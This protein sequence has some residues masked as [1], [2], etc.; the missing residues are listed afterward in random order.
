MANYY[1][2]EELRAKALN[3]NQEDVNALGEWF[4]Q[5]GDCYWNGEYYNADD[6]MRLFPV[7]EEM[8]EDEW[9]LKRYEFR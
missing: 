8:A 2:Y 1:E 5:Y 3:G 9:E 7:Y 4:E 6:G